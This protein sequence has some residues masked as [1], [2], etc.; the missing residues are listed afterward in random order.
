M[1]GWTVRGSE[2][3]QMRHW[4][5]SAIYTMLC[6]QIFSVIFTTASEVLSSAAI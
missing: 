1:E 4:Q 6:T 5:G 3:D 2:T